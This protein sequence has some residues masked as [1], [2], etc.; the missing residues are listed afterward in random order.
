M[1]T[2]AGRCDVLVVGDDQSHF[3][4]FIAEIVDGHVGVA[5]CVRFYGLPRLSLVFFIFHSYSRHCVAS[6]LSY[7]LQ[8][9]TATLR[10][11]RRDVHYYLEIKRRMT[12]HSIS[13]SR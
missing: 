3:V 2:G 4:L 11:H 7:H 5:D 9:T 6:T 1:F 8:T 13:C 10:N 12:L